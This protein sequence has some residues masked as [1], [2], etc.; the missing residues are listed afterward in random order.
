MKS[1]KLR[2]VFLCW[3]AGIV[4]G[5][6]VGPVTALAPAVVGATCLVLYALEWACI[7]G[8]AKLA[9]LAAFVL[10][11]TIATILFCASAFHWP[12]FERL[13]AGG[14]FWTFAIDAW[15]Y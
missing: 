8:A 4:A 9:V 7:G 2:G 15:E 13:Q 1:A 11:L 10:R 12:V 3:I 6:T 5:H 14:G